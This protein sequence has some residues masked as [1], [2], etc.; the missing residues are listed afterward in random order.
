MG[1][2]ARAEARVDL[3]AIRHNVATLRERAGQ[4]EC[5]AVVKADG[6]GHGMLPSARA[7]V[8][9]G[10]AW[11][12]VAFVEEALALRAGG[13]TQRILCWLGSP[14]EPWE[15]AVRD[16][17]DLSAGAVWVLHEIVAAAEQA[18]RPAR[19]HLKAD[20]G[21]GRG[22][23]PPAEWP[24]LLDAALKAQA[25]GSVDVVGVWS[26]L[27]C[28]DEPGHPSVPAQLAAFRDALDAAERAGV[29]PQVRHLANSA[30]TLTVPEARYDLVR[31]GISVYGL[32]PSAQVGSARALGL[33]PAMTFAARLALVKR[34]PAGHG[35]SYGHRYVTAH[36][37]TLG[38]VPVGYADGVP[39]RGSNRLTLLA[40]GRRRTVSGN[41]CMDQF[42]V[43]LGGD[44]A[45]A[46][47]EVL[48]FGPGD[49]GEPTADDWA[50]VLDT[51][52]YEVVT[53]VGP[54]VRRTYTGGSAG[55]EGA[56]GSEGTA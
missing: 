52:A 9:A 7:A 37:T 18:G 35:V 10:A 34:V 5:M 44:P 54:R 42:V 24:T 45:A 23:C 28:A 2:P 15:Q 13:I 40:G 19:L 27:A 56:S 12:G 49:A 55:S 53:G 11:L 26:H 47:D 6:Y 20:T 51:I 36:E 43:D 46:G 8:D 14:Q 39:R 4:A 31:P 17:I 22:G 1:R 3:G 30:G 16:D 50:E 33:R 32:S 41:V 25:T 29:R 38:L 21:L 48:L